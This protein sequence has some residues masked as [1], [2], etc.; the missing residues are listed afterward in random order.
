MSKSDAHGKNYSEAL[1]LISTTDPDSI[2]THANKHFCD[3]SEFT[4]QDLIGHPHN[5][6][7]HPDMPKAA[8]KQMW[9]YLK[10][11]KSW[12]GLVKNKCRDGGHYWVSA[13]VTPIKSEDGRTVEYQSVRSKPT[14]AQ[15]DRAEETYRR[16][17]S[18]TN[19]RQN[20]RPYINAT[21]VMSIIVFASLV[22][23]LFLPD[24]SRLATLFGVGASVLLILTIYLQKIRHSSVKSM[25]EKAY[26]NAE[27]EHIYTG[28]LDDYSS[29]ELA[30]IMK[31][32]ELRAVAGRTGE[33]AEAIAESADREFQ[34]MK[35]V[36]QRLDQQSSETEQVAT[37][38]EE[39]SH[40]IREVADSAGSAT[41]VTDDARQES[42][43]GL[44]SISE[45][46]RVIDQLSIELVNSGKVINELS[47]SSQKIESILDVIGNISEQTN[48]LALNA[49]IE[50]AR[51]GEAGRGFAVVA[52]EV[53]SLANKT[54]S[55]TDEIQEMI[56]QLQETA[57]DAVEIM[58]KGESLSKDCQVRANET[59]DVLNTI[60]SRLNSVTDNSHQIAVAVEQQASVTQEVSRSVS[61][62]RTLAGENL[63]SSRESVSRTESLVSNLNG[64]QRL[65]KQFQS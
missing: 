37:A 45:T 22:F 35:S 49:A 53:R 8:F 44:T 21:L 33:T 2:V 46:L 11:G 52:D 14:T 38:I 51:A 17:R 30:L 39:L 28:H 32:S 31:Q 18:G 10:S 5:V 41:K 27:M 63:E 9:E 55:S 50:A 65:I 36:E 7:R 26:S 62:I 42:E 64:L 40:S 24:L 54:R 34:S 57:S 29:I 59:G 15:I 61:N 43:K 16:L 23:S 25:A 56:S 20:R 3:V 19:R 58:Q 47:E 13:F 1:N 6:V 60:S 12:M 4:E 48:L